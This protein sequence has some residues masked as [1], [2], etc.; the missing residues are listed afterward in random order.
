MSELQWVLYDLKS[1]KKLYSES[2][3]SFHKVMD[4]I[5]DFLN[6]EEVQTYDLTP[7]ESVTFK[8]V[9]DRIMYGLEK[10]NR[11]QA[12]QNKTY[13]LNNDLPKGWKPITKN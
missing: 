1:T 12:G 8:A 6:G 11:Y 2:K 13:S 4:L 7:S 5:M 3:E 10:W 9:Y